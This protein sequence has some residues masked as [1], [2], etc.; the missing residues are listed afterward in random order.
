MVDTLAA[1]YGWTIETIL[2]LT[3]VQVVAILDQISVRK[4]NEYAATAALHGHKMKMKEKFLPKK[5]ELSDEE[6][7]TVE[8]DMADIYK[9]MQKD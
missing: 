3:F 8:A 5:I 7:A 6:T 9:N 2:S 4:H 1:E